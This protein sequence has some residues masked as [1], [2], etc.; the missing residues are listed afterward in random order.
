MNVD[1][2]RAKLL[3]HFLNLGFPPQP[4][5]SGPLKAHMALFG[6]DIPSK[7]SKVGKQ[8]S[9]LSDQETHALG[10]IRRPELINI[11][12]GRSPSAG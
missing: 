12:P 9:E 10:V 7:L 6:K 3:D 8:S 1:Q 5:R 2:R 11:L 4:T